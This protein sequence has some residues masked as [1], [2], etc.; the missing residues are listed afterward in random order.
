MDSDGG[1]GMLWTAVQGRAPGDSQEPPAGTAQQGRGAGPQRGTPPP[2][3][4]R[5]AVNA[6]TFR[7]SSA[8]PAIP[9]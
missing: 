3:P 4:L 8:H 5:A 1:A 9:R 2:G 6:P 7:S